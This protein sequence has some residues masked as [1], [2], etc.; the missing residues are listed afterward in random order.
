MAYG[1][2]E[3]I[4]CIELDMTFATKQMAAE[5]CGIS[6][7]SVNDSLRDG[8]PH[9]GHTFVYE[10]E[11]ALFESNVVTRPNGD[12]RD[13][14]NY[15]GKYQVS[16]TGQVWS[17][18]RVVR[19]LGGRDNPIPGKL[20]TPNIS[21]TGYVTVG[22]TDSDHHTTPVLVHRIVASAFIPNPSNKP[23]V[24]HIDGDKQNNCV[25]NLEWVTQFENNYHAYT[26]GLCDAWSS[27][28]IQY[29]TD[30]AKSVTCKPVRCVTNGVVYGSRSSAAKSLGIGKDAVHNSIKNNRPCNGFMF[31]E[32]FHE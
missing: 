16:S 5:Y 7:G 29:M 31:E 32:V 10:S 18:P 25:D 15:V 22:L 11:R 24:N 21:S 4:Y 17:V 3:P 20:L 13:V 6:R 12:W 9:M 14:P 26:T 30:C 27:E 19:R 1:R 8:K 28:H 2:R 23:Q